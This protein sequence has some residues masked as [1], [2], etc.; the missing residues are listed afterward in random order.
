MTNLYNFLYSP[1][2]KN[3]NGNT[4]FR[5]NES[6]TDNSTETSE[7]KEEN[8]GEKPI[9]EKIREAL[10]DW[11]NKDEADQEYDDTRV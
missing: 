1:G 4:D 11:S 6:Q 5:G 10:Q 7:I 3:G 9:I 8:K 2:G